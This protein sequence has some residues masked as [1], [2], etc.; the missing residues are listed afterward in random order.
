MPHLPRVPG[1]ILLALAVCGLL[2]ALDSSLGRGVAG[3]ELV[4]VPGCEAELRA[5]LRD[6]DS[7]ETS[8]IT[9]DRNYSSNG[10]PGRRVMGDYQARNGFGGMNNDVFVCVTSA[11]GTSPGVATGESTDDD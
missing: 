7:L 2:L 8:N 1:P 4:T 10:T 11:D 5:M 9:V 3:A 6:P